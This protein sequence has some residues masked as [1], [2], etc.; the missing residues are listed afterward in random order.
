M[1]AECPECGQETLHRTL[2]GRMAGKRRLE[3]V[4]KCSRCGNV[5]TEVLEAA[6]HVDVKLILSRGEESERTTARLPADWEL[7]VGDEFMHGDENLLVTGIDVSGRKSRAAKVGDIQT[8]WAKNF[9]RVRVKIA[10]N[11][12]GRT[13]STEILADPDDEFCVGEEIEIDDIPLAIHSIKVRERILR[14]G[15]ATARDIVR[16]YCADTRPARPPRKGRVSRS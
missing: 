8:L 15:S 5:R 16:V 3:M 1:N 2:K 12:H 4:L 7:A 9:D 10:V 6:R 14:R 11:R 13:S